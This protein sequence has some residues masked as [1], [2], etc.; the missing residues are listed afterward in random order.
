MS[1]KKKQPELHLGRAWNQSSKCWENID[2]LW[3]NDGVRLS[4]DPIHNIYNKLIYGGEGVNWRALMD[5]MDLREYNLLAGL[6]NT[7]FQD[8]FVSVGM[9]SDVIGALHVQYEISGMPV[10]GSKGQMVFNKVYRAELPKHIE[11]KIKE[12]YNLALNV[13]AG[14]DVERADRTAE[15]LIRERREL[16]GKALEYAK[17]NVADIEQRIAM[18]CGPENTKEEKMDEEK[19]FIEEARRMRTCARNMVSLTQVT[20]EGLEMKK[21]RAGDALKKETLSNQIMQ[22][23]LL[24]DGYQNLAECL[25]DVIRIYESIKEEK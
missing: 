9:Y 7:G 13:A 3:R 21:T 22:R 10:P 11:E 4:Y 18:L 2:L 5:Y 1:K 6:T 23:R 20:I 15:K 17:A 24:S 14:Y 8:L 19:R 25:Y 12:S 16:L